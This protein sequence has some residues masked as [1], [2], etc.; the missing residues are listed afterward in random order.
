MDFAVESAK[1]IGLL[2]LFLQKW[3]DFWYNNYK[4]HMTFWEERIICIEKSLRIC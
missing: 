4:I 3:H 1:V 2:Q